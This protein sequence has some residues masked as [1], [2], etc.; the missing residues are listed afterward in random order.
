MYAV[1]LTILVRS[2]KQTRGSPSKNPV[3]YCSIWWFMANKQHLLVII[4][5]RN[6]L[7]G[8]VE[9]G[10]VMKKMH[11][12]FQSIYLYP[13]PYPSPPRAISPSRPSPTQPTQACTKKRIDFAFGPRKTSAPRY[14][15]ITPP[16]QG[17]QAG[18]TIKQAWPYSN[19]ILVLMKSKQERK[20]KKSGIS[21]SYKTLDMRSEVK[22]IAGLL[23]V[24]MHITW[25][26]GTPEC[27]GLD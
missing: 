12:P 3:T 25:G 8:P 16:I 27:S 15:D 20:R 1:V 4:K 13:Y 23:R 22:V 5:M 10:S 11:S 18:R 2:E 17:R 7:P 19:N 9:D 21:Q 6:N 26:L 24:V 14:A